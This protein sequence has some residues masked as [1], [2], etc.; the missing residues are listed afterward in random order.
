[1]LKVRSTPSWVT[2]SQQ[3]QFSPFQFLQLINDPTQLPTPSCPPSPP[4]PHPFKLLK[5][6]STPSWVSISQQ[7]PRHLFQF[8]P[9][10]LILYFTEATWAFL[11]PTIGFPHTVPIAFLIKAISLK[12]ILGLKGILWDRRWS[13]SSIRIFSHTCWFFYGNAFIIMKLYKFPSFRAIRA[14]IASQSTFEI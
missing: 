5:V 11:C 14:P 9:N 8:L 2:I 7:F 4:V 6:R 10:H 13:L 12:V 1:M 3:F